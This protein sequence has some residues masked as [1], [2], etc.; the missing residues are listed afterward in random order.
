M[1]E[2]HRPRITILYTPALEQGGGIGRYVRELVKALARLDRKSSYQLFVAG[3]PDSDIPK[4]PG[5]NF[6][7][8]RTA[9]N[10]EWLGRIWHKAHL[11]IPLELWAGSFDLIHA[12]DFTLPP[13]KRG[14]S[15]ILTVHDLAF[16]RTPET[17]SPG[18][19]RYLKRVV[20]RSIEQADHVLADSE[21]TRQDILDYYNTP[22]DKVSVLYPGVEERFT[23]AVPRNAIHAVRQKY[24]IGESPFIL[25]LGTI[26]PRKNYARLAEAVHLLDSPDIKLVIAGGKGWLDDDLYRQIDR[27]GLPKIVQFIGYVDDAD[28]PALYCAA[29]V[30]ALPSLYEGFGIPVLEAMA[31]GT[32]V[33]TSSVSSLPE[34]AGGAGLLVNPLDSKE[35]ALGL[36]H[37]LDD[38]LL[39]ASCREKGIAQA[40]QFTWPRAAHQL[41]DT[42]HS[43]L[44]IK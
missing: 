7:W 22:P 1:P 44:A 33:L 36:S 23:Q 13:V 8:C 29:E 25:S 40:R 35:I 28:L 30:F 18:L 11:P 5:P 9:L 42:Y 10:T 38:Q 16:L 39:R 21:S 41:L 4:T 24:R 15:T 20:P 3:I 34:A 32:P 14:T 19:R 27:Q 43:V 12:T 6:S 2:S 37:L 31:C 26:Q 17:A